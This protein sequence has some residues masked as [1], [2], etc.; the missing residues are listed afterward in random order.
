MV[1]FFLI[2][3]LCQVVA[4]FFSSV[5][6]VLN[7]S[8]SGMLSVGT[9]VSIFHQ[10]VLLLLIYTFNLFFLIGFKKKINSIY[11]YLYLVCIFSG[12]LWF[13]FLFFWKI[14]IFF[15]LSMVTISLA[16]FY[17]LHSKSIFLFFLWTFFFF[18]KKGDHEA[19]NH[20]VFENHS[21][22]PL[23]IFDVLYMLDTNMSLSVV[24]IFFVVIKKNFFFHKK[25]K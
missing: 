4:F 24:F 5:F 3:Y 17:L 8:L 11:V 22:L 18:S 2:K 15:F 19:P 7:M 16:V 13:F 21:Y 25:K 9:L 1:L 6:V 20:L 23:Q 12:N 14:S 10:K